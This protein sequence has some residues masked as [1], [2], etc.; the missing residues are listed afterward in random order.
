MAT[1]GI[2]ERGT[3]WCIGNGHS[4]HIWEDWWLPKPNSFRVASP[5]R[6]QREA[7]MVSDLMDPKKRGWNVDKVRRTFLPH[8]VVSVLSILVSPRLLEDSVIWGWTNNGSFSLKA[9]MV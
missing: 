3:R 9:H 1:K 5:R 2:I 6:P 8:E 4:V 7:E